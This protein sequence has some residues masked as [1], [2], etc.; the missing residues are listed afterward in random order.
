M[1]LDFVNIF[2]SYKEENPSLKTFAVQA[3]SKCKMIFFVNLYQFIVK[4]A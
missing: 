3:I 4:P 1:Q 2:I